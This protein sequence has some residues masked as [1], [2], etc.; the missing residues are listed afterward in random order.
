MIYSHYIIYTFHHDN[1][2]AE[3]RYINL[4]KMMIQQLENEKIL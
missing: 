4:Q 2:K 1:I 3:W